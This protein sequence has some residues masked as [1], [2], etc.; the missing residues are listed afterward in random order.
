MRKSC[1][2]QREGREAE[3]AEEALGREA[4]LKLGMAVLA[5]R[6]LRPPAQC[7]SKLR[8][9]PTLLHSPPTCPRRRARRHRHPAPAAGA[10]G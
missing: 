6:H 10:A 8:L 7:A 1:C 3:E 4:L 2:K 5:A 9:L